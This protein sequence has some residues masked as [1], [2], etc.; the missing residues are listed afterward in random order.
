M[1]F[2]VLFDFITPN[3]LIFPR[4]SERKQQ[5]RSHRNCF[6]C[7]L[8]LICVTQ[9]GLLKGQILLVMEFLLFTL[10]ASRTRYMA[11]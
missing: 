1:H 7:W 5:L 6:S 9:Q 2:I 8:F 11:Q 4:V 10:Q 3:W